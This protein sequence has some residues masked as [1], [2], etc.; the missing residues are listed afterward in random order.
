MIYEGK[1]YDH[2][3]SQVIPVSIQLHAESLL[4][5]TQG[6]VKRRWIWLLTEIKLEVNDPAFMRITCE[7]PV[8]GT[9]EVQDKSLIADLLRIYKPSGSARLYGLVLQGGL[10]VALAALAVIAAI[11]MVVYFWVLPPL[12][13]KA[14]DLVPLSYDKEL[15]TLAKNQINE[16][17]DSAASQLL[18][19]FASQIQW[20]VKDTITFS[21]VKSD[22]INAYALPGGYIV[23]YSALLHK[24]KTPEELAALLSHEISHIKYR[25][26]MRSLVRNLSGYLFG[27]L[28]F[29]DVNG[30]M[31]ALFKNADQLRTLQYSRKFEEEADLKGLEMMRQNKINQQGMLGLMEALKKAGAEKSSISIPEFISTHPLTDHR[32][33]YVQQTMLQHPAKDSTNAVRDSIFLQLKAAVK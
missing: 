29:N 26:S 16:K 25:H 32:I 2:Q 11:A 1:Y 30:M 10:K 20:D 19:A 21:V 12:A 22:V 15:G 23:V 18:T 4:I 3:S 13:D 27:S 9:I 17:P 31:A 6:E 14:I 7:S 5:N 28:V 8:P 24:L 33:K